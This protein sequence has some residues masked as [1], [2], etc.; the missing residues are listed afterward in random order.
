MRKFITFLRT[1][2][3]ATCLLMIHNTLYILVDYVYL[4]NGNGTDITR[5]LSH[6]KIVYAVASVPMWLSH[7]VDFK[8]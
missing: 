4:S 7:L 8:Q 2:F 6:V 3:I 1:K 5:N